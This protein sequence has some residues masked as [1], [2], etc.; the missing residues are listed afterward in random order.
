MSLLILTTA[1]SLPLDALFGRRA[2]KQ[3]WHAVFVLEQKTG[4]TDHGR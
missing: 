4:G 2:V 1:L 3:S